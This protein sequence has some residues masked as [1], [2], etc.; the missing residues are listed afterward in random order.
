MEVIFTVEPRDNRPDGAA[1]V[2]R[3]PKEVLY[4]PGGRQVLEEVVGAINQSLEDEPA[5]P[6]LLSD[7]R[8]Q[9]KE[10]QDDLKEVRDKADEVLVAVQNTLNFIGDVD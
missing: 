4:L 10:I 8:G 1:A 2:M 3:G 9:V 6:S 7:I 5:D